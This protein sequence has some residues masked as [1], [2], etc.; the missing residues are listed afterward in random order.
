MR[1]AVIRQFGEPAVLSVETV[2]DRSPGRGE[3]VID[4]EYASVTFVETQV[5]AGRPPNPA[6]QPQLPIVLGNGVGGSVIEVGSDVD[7]DLVGQAVVSTTG[8]SGGYA[9]RVVVDAGLPIA[10]PD[11]VS[12]RDAVALLADGR[13]ALAL[14]RAAHVVAGETVLVEAA[15]GGVGTCLVQL[16]CAAGATV[17]AGAGSS[18]KLAVP[19]RLGAAQTIDYSQDGWEQRVRDEFGSVDVVF[20]GVGGEIGAGAVG[21]LVPSGRFCRYGMASGAYTNAATTR[22]DVQ[23]ID[24]AALS[25]AQSRQLSVEALDLAAS[26]QLVATIGQ[27]HPLERAADAHSAIEARATIGKTLLQVSGGRRSAEAST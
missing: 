15:A 10:L 24:G 16:A 9:E 19:E 2:S 21:L 26:G 17:V 4:V 5:R 3:V 8:G 7:E 13:T 6:M 27:E 14:L 25:P 23:V 20:D 22:P 12:T 11:G 1:A 18:R